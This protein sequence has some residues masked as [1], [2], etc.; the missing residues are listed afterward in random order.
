MEPLDP[1]RGVKVTAML[2]DYA[3]A[4]DG[5]LIAV[6]AGWNVIGPQPVP[7]AFAMLVEVPWQLTN[8][9]H[10]VR[11]ELIDLDGNAVTP[12][13]AEDPAAVEVQFEIGRPPGL[14]PGCMLPV[15]LP[16]NHGPLPLPPG[17]HFEW[18]LT[19]NGEARE[20][21]RLAFSTR[22]DARSQAA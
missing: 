13:G 20:D 1:E 17:G 10:T 12:I 4:A 15:P 7:F 18:R 3:T 6:G 8:K 22:P 11:L 21:W 14:R 5:K 16:I 19:V 9:Q 2:A